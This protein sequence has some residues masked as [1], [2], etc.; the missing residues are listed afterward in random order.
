MKKILFLL[1]LAFILSSCYEDV[2]QVKEP[3]KVTTISIQNLPKDTVLVS[4][5]GETLYVFD[6]KTN[7]VKYKIK[8]IRENSIPVHDLV[9]LIMW[10]LIAFLIV[11]III[12][13]TD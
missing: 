12:A 6:Q 10:F 1:V 13:K 11:G 5:E 9:F 3:E 7:L 2:K 8:N 4:I